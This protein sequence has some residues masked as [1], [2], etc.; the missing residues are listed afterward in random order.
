[1]PAVR[2][3]A[4]LPAAAAGLK[5]F[6]FV[7]N[8]TCRPPHLSPRRPMPRPPGPQR[9]DTAPPARSRPPAAGRAICCRGIPFRSRPSQSRHDR[10]LPPRQQNCGGSARPGG[11]KPSFY[12]HEGQ[13]LSGTAVTG[14]TG[15]AF[16][17][18]E[19]R[20]NFLF[21]L[22]LCL[23]AV[24]F[25]V[26]SLLLPTFPLLFLPFRRP[27]SRCPCTAGNP[28]TALPQRRKPSCPPPPFGLR[29]TRTQQT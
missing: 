16:R 24:L 23:P 6:P 18:G 13:N 15:P 9:S 3:C 25:C 10:F 14:G 21:H 5:P 7:R 22:L 19:P 20:S 28:A 4:G 17:S 26:F 29:E 1:M 8:A 2:P 12:W 11:G 27:C